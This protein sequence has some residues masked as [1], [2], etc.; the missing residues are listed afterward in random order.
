M[1]N[2][3]VKGTRQYRKRNHF[4]QDENVFDCFSY[5]GSQLKYEKFEDWLQCDLEDLQRE[6]SFSLMTKYQKSPVNS[7][8]SVYPQYPWLIWKFKT[9]P[10]GFWKEITNRR[11]FF[12]WLG[13]E[14]G[15]ETMADWYRISL[16]D[17]VENGG[18]QMIFGYYSGS[19]S[20]ALQEVY[21]EFRWD[22]FRFKVLP[23]LSWKDEKVLFAFVKAIEENLHITSHS[24]WYRVSE[25]QIEL[26]G[27]MQYFERNGG[28][29]MVLKRFYP[30]FLWEAPKFAS[31]AKKSSQRGLLL[32]LRVLLPDEQE[33]EIH[34]EHTVQRDD[35]P[36]EFDAYVP[37]LRL[38]FEFQ[39]AHHYADSSV[40]GTT[41]TAHSTI[42]E[43]D[44]KKFRYCEDNG[45]I[46]VAVPYWW[47]KSVKTLASMIR[48][49]CPEFQR[50][51]QRKL[52][53][54]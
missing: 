21:P 52:A 45:I 42:Q 17:I 24:D 10:R 12:D 47:D 6:G 41:T 4:L 46:L 53:V 22:V 11:H 18:G 26:T 13:V 7:I 16:T 1:S 8:I 40:F 14:L 23:K 32:A 44:N 37:A 54:E 27:S 15:I 38:A 48:G 33:F 50:Y 19:P 30:T 2:L 51:E 25:D 43:R 35:G 34:E 36:M 9:V 39:G 5:I 31:N 29:Y 28:L 3:I 49:K 20:R